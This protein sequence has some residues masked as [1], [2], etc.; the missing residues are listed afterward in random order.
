MLYYSTNKAIKT[1]HSIREARRAK[2]EAVMTE[3]HRLSHIVWENW[4]TI[5]LNAGILEDATEHLGIRIECVPADYWAPERIWVQ[6]IA[7]S[8]TPLVQYKVLHEV[9]L[10]RQMCVKYID[11]VR[12]YST[13]HHTFTPKQIMGV[14]LGVAK[15][16]LRILGIKNI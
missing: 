15:R 7:P 13:D 3:W 14:N 12:N 8:E 16:V 10:H 2:Y 6:F 5:Y 4:D 11:G 1:I 9:E